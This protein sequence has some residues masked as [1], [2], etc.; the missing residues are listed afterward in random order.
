MTARVL[1]VDDVP[2]NLKVLEAKLAAEYFEVITAPSGAAALETCAREHPDIV[3][4]DVMMPGMDGFEVCRAIKYDPAL[5]HIP[6]VMLTALDQPA[7]RVLGLEAGADDFLTKPV[8]DLALMARLRSLIRIKTLT[9]ELRMREATSVEFGI[10][11]PLPPPDVAVSAR[12]LLVEDR[13]PAARRVASALEGHHHLTIEADPGSALRIV[14]DGAV[15]IAIVSATST[16][17]DGLRF[18]SQL[19]SMADTRNMP[20]LVLVEEGDTKRLARALDLGVN[21]YLNRPV[22]RNELLAR[23]K[24]QVRRK[25][26]AD[27]LRENL[28]LSLEMAVTDALTGLFNRRYMTSH[29]GGLLRRSQAEQR[30]LSVL[31][32]DIDHFKAVNDTRGHAVGDVVLKEV[33]LRIARGVRGVDLACRYGGE[34]F[35][36]IMPD[37]DLAGAVKVAERMRGQIADHPFEIPGGALTVTASFGVTVARAGDTPEDMVR[38][39]DAALYQAKRD[40][41]NR[42]EVVPV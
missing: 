19:R 15:D 36:V 40:G 23:L 39:A 33:A 11:A 17:F 24:T 5:Q 12:V 38:R 2:M 16:Q 41:R 21:D 4:L 18:C 1:I 31:F 37:T 32:I 26:Y 34:E 7:D 30:D 35:V 22:E 28:H 6:V 13:E 9:D 42:V 14:R 8:N 20:I 3:L 29:L 27:R 25:L 10:L